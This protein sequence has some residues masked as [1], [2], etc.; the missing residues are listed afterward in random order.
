VDR[1]RANASGT[2]VKT[3]N[4]KQ[5]EEMCEKRI[6]AWWLMGGPAA[7]VHG[8]IASTLRSGVSVAVKAGFTLLRTTISAS[9]IK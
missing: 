4:A 6:R 1:S 3:P 2:V 8:L 7:H 5:R 9:A